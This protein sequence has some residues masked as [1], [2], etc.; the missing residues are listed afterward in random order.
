MMGKLPFD[1]S[2]PETLTKF[3]RAVVRMVGAPKRDLAAVPE[4]IPVRAITSGAA[5][6]TR[7]A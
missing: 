3:Q 7:D 4:G 6:S 1:D 5:C 2:R